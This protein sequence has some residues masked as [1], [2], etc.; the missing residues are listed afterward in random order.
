MTVSAEHYLV[1]LSP[2][3]PSSTR[4]EAWKEI[5]RLVLRQAKPAD[6]VEVYDGLSLRC[7]TQIFLPTDARLMS[8][9][10]A[11]LRHVSAGLNAVQAFLNNSG[12]N[13]TPA[14]SE[15]AA[16]DEPKLL[17]LAGRQIRRAGQPLTV[18][19]VGSPLYRNEQEPAF[20]FTDG[21]YPSDGHLQ[22]MEGLTPFSTRD[23][24][25]LLEGVTVYHATGEGSESAGL[26]A[27]KVARFWSLY[28]SSQG[29]TLAGYAGSLTTIGTRLRSGAKEAFRPAEIDPAQGKMEMIRQQITVP[30]NDDWM[31]PAELVNAPALTSAVV[32]K[33]YIG[34][35]WEQP[36]DVDIYGS[37][38]GQPDLF[39]GRRQTAEGVHQRDY[40]VA[41]QGE[42]T[43]ETIEFMRPTDLRQVQA[44]L[45]LYSGQ[46][47]SP[48][49]AT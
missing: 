41:P 17:T 27:E 8:T 26:H 9:E 39:Y 4:A 10:R 7:I 35:R 49:K 3:L 6:V 20:N 45:N 40:R 42:A 29:G 19:L 47:R 21:Y 38:R 12:A 46:C 43:Y 36:V 22:A 34:V 48:L 23:R 32:S 5:T 25:K 15:D 31:K 13:D 44:A 1:A 33:L 28:V 18:V 24:A 11:R 2:R 30:R 37:T 16:L 14:G